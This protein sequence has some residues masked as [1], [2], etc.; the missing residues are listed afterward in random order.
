MVYINYIWK[1]VST[2][3][4][5][6]LENS[7]YPVESDYMGPQNKKSFSSNAENK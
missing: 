3:N 5:E 1:L 7:V 4:G 6:S 2:E